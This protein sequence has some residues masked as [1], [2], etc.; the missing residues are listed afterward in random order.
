MNVDEFRAAI[1]ALPPLPDKTAHTHKWQTHRASLRRHIL[2]EDPNNF[3]AWS[4]VRATMHVGNFGILDREY[5]QLSHRL[6]FVSRDSGFGGTELYMGDNKL[7]TNNI[8]Q[9]H[10]LKVLMDNYDVD[11]QDLISIAE[12]GGGYGS[13][14][15][16]FHN[17]EFDGDYYL[18]DLPEF[19]LLQEFYL[20]NIGIDAH[21]H[22]EFDPLEV[23]L[24]IAVTSISETPIALRDRFFKNIKARYYCIRFQESYFDVDNQAYF[25]RFAAETPGVWHVIRDRFMRTHYYFI[26]ERAGGIHYAEER[27]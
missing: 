9:A 15:S 27:K 26:G 17:L 11:I 7:G 24:F 20:S 4:T 10:V 23:D 12:F 8:H 22:S 2:N 1:R 6:H 14:C 19:L 13:M 25:E 3:I 21:Y 5:A 18:Y 16:I